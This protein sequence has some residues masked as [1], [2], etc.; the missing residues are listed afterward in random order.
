LWR[1]VAAA[2]ALFVEHIGS[3]EERRKFE[4]ALNPPTE[5][6][7]GMDAD[8]QSALAALDRLEARWW[9]EDPEVAPGEAPGT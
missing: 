4:E 8:S 9:G 3:A 7:F 2:Y 6:T 1:S 5:E